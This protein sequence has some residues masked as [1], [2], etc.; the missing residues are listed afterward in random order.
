MTLRI[1]LEGGVR[2][3]AEGL[4]AGPG[5]E[6]LLRGGL[7]L[8]PVCHEPRPTQVNGRGALG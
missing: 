7:P 6:P 1:Q 4:H 2:R 3:W 8:S 5:A